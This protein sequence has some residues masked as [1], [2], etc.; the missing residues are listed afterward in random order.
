MQSALGIT[1]LRLACQRG[2]DDVVRL[3]LDCHRCN[4]NA[5]STKGS[6][7]ALHIAAHAGRRNV[8]EILF[9]HP[10]VRSNMRNDA[11]QTA[12]DIFAVPPS[13][14][15]HTALFRTLWPHGEIQRRWF[16]V[17]LVC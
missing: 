3:L 9:N 11:G 16:A 15:I 6:H 14:R 2:K 12:E 13:P 1:A 8:I 10:R 17:G 5:K 4:P 7:T